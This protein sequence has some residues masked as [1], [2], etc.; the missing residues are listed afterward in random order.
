MLDSLVISQKVKQKGVATQYWHIYTPKCLG[1]AL[2]PVHFGRGW[3]GG[4]VTQCLGLGGLGIE[5]VNRKST[6][7]HFCYKRWGRTRS[8]LLHVC[9]CVRSV[10]LCMILACM[11]LY[12][13]HLP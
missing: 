5:R 2:G 12:L 6:Q 10:K 4:G 9:V 8:Y 11:E 13:F 7:R 1:C 3:G